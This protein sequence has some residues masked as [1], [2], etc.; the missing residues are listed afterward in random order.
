[1]V[2]HTTLAHAIGCRLTPTHRPIEPHT[3]LAVFDVLPRPEWRGFLLQD[4]D[5]PPRECSSRH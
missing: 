4:G 3:I 2:E 5:V 1:M